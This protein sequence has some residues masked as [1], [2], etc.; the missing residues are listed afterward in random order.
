MGAA[1]IL[2]N[3]VMNYLVDEAQ[4]RLICHLPFVYIYV[5]DA[6]LTIP[7]FLVN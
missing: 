4:K 7:R 2:A 5:D 3:L 6:L 1:P